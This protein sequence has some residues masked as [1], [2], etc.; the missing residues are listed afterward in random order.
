MSTKRMLAIA[1]IGLFMIAVILGMM[2][3]LP[4]LDRKKDLV[5]LLPEQ[6]E[7]PSTPSEMPPD[8]HNRVVVTRDTVQD[9]VETL[10]RPSSYSRTISVERY[11]DGGYDMHEI[12]VSVNDGLTSLS[13][14]PSVGSD[15]RII[16]TQ[17]YLYIWDV[18]DKIPYSSRIGSDEVGI[19]NADQWQM[20]VSYEDLLELNLEDIIEAGYTEYRGE[21]CIY[22]MYVSP[23]LGYVGV[24][25]ISIDVGLI[26]GAEE[27]DGY[28]H[29]I[30]SMTAAEC[31]IG[32]PDDSAFTLPDGTLVGYSYIS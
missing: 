14:H 25:Y 28:G 27:H 18:G 20:L 10:V 12:N 6:T 26:I 23:Q 21:Y 29:P 9:V 2:W 30:Y 31:A 24:F 19:R 8:A 4:Y 7:T 5:L 13:I 15:K 32:P 22:A 11:W 1:V 16:I 17:D 3:L